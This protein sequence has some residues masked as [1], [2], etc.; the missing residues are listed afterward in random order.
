[1]Y[2][3]SLFSILMFTLGCGSLSGETGSCTFAPSLVNSGE[4][5]SGAPSAAAGM[6]TVSFEA[7]ILETCESFILNRSGGF[8]IRVSATV[9]NPN[10]YLTSFSAGT[11]RTLSFEDE[12]AP[13]LTG[14]VSISRS[15]SRTEAGGEMQLPWADQPEKLHVFFAVPESLLISEYPHSVR[16]SF[17]ENGDT[18]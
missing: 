15:I 11:G 10:S 8:D 14:S 2:R 7:S 5:V 18:F 6:K 4:Q 13:R 12:E 1:M 9:P 3:L 17:Q 16:V